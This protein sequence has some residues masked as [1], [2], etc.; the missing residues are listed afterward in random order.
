MTNPVVMVVDDD[1]GVRRGL[2]RDLTRRFGCDYR[3]VTNSSAVLDLEALR[4]LKSQGGDVALLIAD[5]WMPEMTGV[6][7]LSRAHE[8]HPSAKR[9][10]LVGSGTRRRRN[11]SRGP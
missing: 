10:L 3:V 4:A 1:E 11:V 8:L 2:D 9:V 5:Q 7:F 6:D